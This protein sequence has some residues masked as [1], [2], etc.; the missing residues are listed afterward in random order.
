MAFQEVSSSSSSS[1]SSTSSSSSSTRQW[2]Y[3]VFLS[4][5]GE[6]TRNNFT[7]HLYDALVRMAI[8][9]Y[10]DDDDL[11]RG[12]NISPALLK[13]IEESRISVI[14]FSQNYASSSWCLDELVKILE[15]RE[16][17]E[18]IVVPV[19]Y[20]VDPSEVRHQR[21][22]FGVAFAKHEERFKDK[23]MMVQKWRTALTQVSNLSGWHLGNRSEPEFIREIIEWVNLILVKKTYFQVAQYPVGIE[24]RV[25]K[26]K[27]LLDIEKNDRIRMVGI[28]GTRGIGKTTLSKA[29]YNSIDAQFECSCFLENISEASSQKDGLIQLQNKLLSKI[30]GNSSQVVDNVDRGSTLIK[31][32]LSRL[33]ILLVLDDVDDSLQL[34][35]LAGKCDWFGLGSRIIITTRDKPLLLAHGVYSTYEMNGLDHDESLQLFCWNAF[36]RDKPNDGYVEIAE[37]AVRHSGGLPLDLTTLG[38]ALKKKRYTLLEKKTG[39]V[40]KNF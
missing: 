15:C 40:Q 19:F 10:R 6:D 30:L 32:R 2:V 18:Q 9:T 20:K 13:A 36:K 5:R 33:R 37:D 14:V 28:F 22:S 4:F 27:S 8:N 11:K 31:Q 29:I 34:E 3:D 24:S 39:R 21:K 7:A 26:V 35:K 16:T 17:M 38:L 23:Q 25:Q 1:L 12:E